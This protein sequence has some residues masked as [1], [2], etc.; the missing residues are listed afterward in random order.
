[1]T[2]GGS[3]EKVVPESQ[4]RELQGKI[5]RVERIVG[6]KTVDIEIHKEA[7]CI[8]CVKKNRSR[9]SHWSEWIVSNE[10]GCTIHES[11]K[12]TP[13]VKKEPDCHAA[14]KLTVGPVFW[15]EFSRNRSKAVLSTS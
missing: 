1:L 11:F 10:A 15:E 5:R 3:E 9:G 8:V 7:V 4:V 13:F 12:V 2:E 14:F 6:Q